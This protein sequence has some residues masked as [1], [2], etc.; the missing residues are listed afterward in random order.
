MKFEEALKHL[1]NGGKVTRPL[2]K[3]V[4]AYY[5]IIK[6]QILYRVNFSETMK[7]HVRFESDYILAEDWEIA[8]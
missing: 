1:R 7:A 4:D 3:E 8:E 2:E 5:Q 6:G